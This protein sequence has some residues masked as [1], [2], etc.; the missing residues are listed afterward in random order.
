MVV[1]EGLLTEEE[2]EE[3]VV[4]VRVVLVV[5]VVA[6]VL[7]AVSV[8]V[9]PSRGS[10]MCSRA[11]RDTLA[12]YAKETLDSCATEGRKEVGVAPYY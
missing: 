9:A 11:V 3:V 1:L 6:V 7:A 8:G 10:Y 5:V 4:V 2:E 12:D